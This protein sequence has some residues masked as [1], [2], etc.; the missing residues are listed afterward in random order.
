MVTAAARLRCGRQQRFMK[1]ARAGYREPPVEH[2]RIR[3]L[4]DG[5]DERLGERVPGIITTVAGIGYGSGT[6][7]GAYSGDGGLATNAEFNGPATVAVDAA[8]D[9]FIADSGNERIRKV[10]FP[11]QTLELID[12]SAGSAGA[13][14]IVVSSPFGSVTS[15]V[16]NVNVSLPATIDLSE[17]QTA[18]GDTKFTF[19]LSGSAGSSYVLQVSTNLLNWSSVTTSTIPVT[20]SI[21]LTNSISGYNRSFYR[22]YLQ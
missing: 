7:S 17:P 11:G 16:I 21:A 8:G 10:T 3:I 1:E 9:L 20:G 12:V 15:S 22:A 6:G 13:Y 5:G 19:L 2:Q 18:S 4:L 14:E